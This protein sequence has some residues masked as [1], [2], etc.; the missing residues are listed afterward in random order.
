[1]G[2]PFPTFIRLINKPLTPPNGADILYAD[3]QNFP[4]G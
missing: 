2:A 4:G 3:E 1:M